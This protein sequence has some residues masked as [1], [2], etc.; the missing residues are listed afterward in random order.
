MSS[1]LNPLSDRATPEQFER[2]EAAFHAAIEQPEKQ[3]DAVLARL[4]ADDAYLIA[5][6]QR[7]LRAHATE[8]VTLD[9]PV[10]AN[11][12][13][14]EFRKGMPAVHG[15]LEPGALLGAWRIEREIARGGMSTVYLAHREGE[16]YR[17][18]AAIKRIAADADPLRFADER[19]ILAG[20]DHPGIARL[21]DGGVSEDGRLWL[22]TEYVEGD[23][24]DRYCDSRAIDLRA[25]IGLLI[26]I[27][28]AVAHAHSHLVVHRDIKPGNILVTEN[29]HARLLDFGI[30][31]LL[32]PGAEATTR[33][34]VALMTPQYA[35]P[36]Q[37]LGMAIT[38]QTDV[39][40]LGILAC[41]LLAG[42]N[43]FA[44]PGDPLI[45]L[46]R[47]I[48]DD[49]AALPSALCTDLQR[50]RELRGDLDAIV[51]K[52]L[53]KR[54]EDRYPTA[55]RFAEDL[56]NYLMGE[57]VGA[58][59][60]SR[61]YR[62]RS[63]LRKYRWP[64]AGVA[65]VLVLA[66][67]TLSLRL[68]QVTRERDNANAVAGFLGGLITDLDPGARNTANAEQ[69]S[70]ADVLDAG[71]ARLASSDLPAALRGQLLV[72]LAQGYNGMLAWDK[73][74][75]TARDARTILADVEASDEMRFEAELAFG[76]A[77]RGGKQNEKAHSLYAGMLTR[78]NLDAHAHG[79]VA[80]DFGQS[81][82][83][84][85]KLDEALNQLE[86]AQ[87]DLANSGDAV[88]EASTLRLK[89]DTLSRL[90]RKDE[91]IASAADALALAKERFPKDEIQRGITEANYASMLREQNPQ[92]AEPYFLSAIA[93]FRRVLGDDHPN[94]L[95]AQNNYALLLRRAQRMDEAEL[96]LEEILARRSGIYGEESREVGETLQNLA[97]L[98][99]ER[100][101]YA[102]CIKTA[103][104]A[105][106]T[107]AKALPQDHYYR[108][109]PL[110]TIGGAQLASGA[111][112][113]AGTTLDQADAI[114]ATS[115]P[116]DALPR[117][118][119][120][121]RQAMVLAALDRC[122]EARPILDD[123]FKT[124]DERQQATYAHEFARAFDLCAASEAP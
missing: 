52:A 58:R 63:T 101:D 117:Q 24:I 56:Q 66:L 68:Q 61:G 81:L 94:T 29:G 105:E 19:R 31:K 26:D 80:K 67:A 73:A 113:E 120:R 93:R 116:D 50:R 34:G 87:A 36:E 12:S 100:G 47:A 44:A 59:R 114:L 79:I 84:V 64:L 11:S 39:H 102:G 122:T 85:G 14:A 88:A 91:A 51:L 111:F 48:V 124:L 121:A 5:T 106:S 109:F 95:N 78:A 107:L 86:R 108:A 16:G 118:I 54:P 74:A 22:A 110:L 57:P 38:A 43:P 123:S 37:I 49:E 83:D 25:R 71:R 2:I 70:V 35:A 46:T 115:L 76:T 23:R 104:R 40:A 90:G 6:A 119:V 53:R 30:A 10:L 75:V 99:Y 72:R 41:E 32:E 55:A 89:A 21:I 18:A 92:Q 42:C 28:A 9:H 33:T 27:A 60:G 7:L 1:W 97:A 3:R 82:I 69:L 112:H 98:L 20:L 17:L 8:H 13:D 62:L 15:G 65:A 96:L 4:L 103:R 77:L 45:K